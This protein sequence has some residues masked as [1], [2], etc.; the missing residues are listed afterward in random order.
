MNIIKDK[1]YSY[2]HTSDESGLYDNCNKKHNTNKC[3]RDYECHKCDRNYECHKCDRDYECHKCDKHHCKVCPTGA[4]GSTG[5]T[6]NTGATGATGSTGLTG[7]TGI[8]GITGTT[9]AT[10]STGVTGTTGTTGST[11]ITGTTGT[12]GSTG[13]TGTTGTTGSTGVTGTTGT[14]GSTGVTG[15]T[16]TTGSTGVTGTTGTTGSTGITGTTGNTGAGLPAFAYI[17]STAAQSVANTSAV[18]FNGPATTLAP[19]SFTAPS[20]TITLSA[21]TYL[22]SF[23][24]SVGTGGGSTW[25]IAVNGGITQPLS[26]TSRSGNSQVWGAAVITIAAASTISIVNNSG[27][28]INLVNG[29]APTPNTSVS[30]SINIL[31]LN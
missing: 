23:E 25:A 10:G 16:G 13:I 21:G 31:K 24:T 4:T 27:G 22:I 29:L 8:T 7:A 3:D 20:S 15:T 19:I 12:T 1:N 5:L 18:I 2:W 30:A 26:Y 17:Y 9:G 14:T 28:A 11:G 6:G